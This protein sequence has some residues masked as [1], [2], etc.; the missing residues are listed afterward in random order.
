MV[1]NNIV[2]KYDRFMIK[3]AWQIFTTVGGV[4]VT[5]RIL[6]IPFSPPR[7]YLTDALGSILTM[8]QY[9]TL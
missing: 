2:H 1:Q 8:L 3:Y 7:R 4:L 9:L 5:K 6:F